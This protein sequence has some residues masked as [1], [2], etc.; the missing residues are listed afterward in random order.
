MGKKLRWLFVAIIMVIAFCTIIMIGCSDIENTQITITY[1]TAIGETPAQETITFRQLLNGEFAL[2]VL[3]NDGYSFLGWYLD[4]SFSNK[5]D[6]ENIY[7]VIENGDLQL[8]AKW[9]YVKC[10][11]VLKSEE[12]ENV[13]V[14]L[15][16]INEYMPPI[17]EKEG[18][19]FD[20][21]FFDKEHTQAYNAAG[22]AGGVTTDLY[23]KFTINEYKLIVKSEVEQVYTLEYDE[24]IN[25]NAIETFG[26]LVQGYYIDEAC[27]Q[28]F[29]IVNMPAKDLVIYPK[30]CKHKW[31]CNDTSNSCMICENCLEES[32]PIIKIDTG[33][34]EI[35]R[36]YITSLVT[37][38]SGMAKYNFEDVE[39][40]I[41]IRGNG[42]AQFDKKPYR[43][44][45]DKKQTMLGLNNSLKA[46][47]WVLLAEYRGNL[48][49]NSLA[50][51]LAKGIFDSNY[52]VSDYAYVKVYIDDNYQG[53]YLLAEQQQVNQ[54]RIEINEPEKN[55]TATDIGYLLELDSYYA[56]EDNW[57]EIDYKH[58]LT[59]ANN[60]EIM[61]EN[62][63]S[64]YTIKS[65]IYSD[66][67]KSFIQKVVQNIWDI[68]YDTVYEDHANFLDKPYKTLD[69]NFD[70]VE[71]SNILS[72]KEAISRVIDYDSLVQMFLLQ[73]IVQNYDVAWSSFYVSIDCSETGNK[74]LTFQAPWDFDLAFMEIEY[75]RESLYLFSKREIWYAYEQ[76][77]FM[78]FAQCGW[79]VEDVITLWVEAQNENLLEEIINGKQRF[80]S[81]SVNMIVENYYLW[82]DDVMESNLSSNETKN[83][84][85]SGNINIVF[86]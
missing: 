13:E 52:Y 37:V 51:D 39:C 33:N 61:Q 65:D 79:F 8:Y 45:F 38:E 41:K 6:K 63:Q 11:I 20:G 30:Y 16:D 62:M 32:F 64:H 66:N 58:G 44:K 4:N 46:K 85:F 47:S 14:N 43:L 83:Y 10:I 78:V 55:S 80:I 73:E 22:V 71:D 81:Q 53:I 82:G 36:D 7:N 74:K 34:Q 76:P 29:N 5:Y 84:L 35:T 75:N 42:S 49:K 86:K 25:V 28:V 26:H 40:Q 9:D 57:I 17:L 54:G 68:V 18:Y 70:I 67:Q 2:P 48:I 59:T 50:F 31:I 60:E 19:T 12:E 56:T 27:N 1:N 24:L 3:E 72:A 77:W 23:P 69:S 21:W 15:L